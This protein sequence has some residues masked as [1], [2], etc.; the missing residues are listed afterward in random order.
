MDIDYPFGTIF[1]SK[2]QAIR[3]Q[4]LHGNNIFQH[5]VTP[6]GRFDSGGPVA[7]PIPNRP[8]ARLDEAPMPKNRLISGIS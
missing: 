6:G 3:F 7:A 1:E 8:S 4:R 5:R 2:H